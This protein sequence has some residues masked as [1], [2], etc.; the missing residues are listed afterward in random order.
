MASKYEPLNR[1]LLGHPRGEFV[2]TFRQVEEVLG[3]ALP[4]SAERPQWWS[5]VTGKDH[6]HSQAWQS[7]GY[8]AFLVTG[9]K[10]VRFASR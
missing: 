8:G 7:A 1:Y 3:F 2:L 10:E 4:K 5:N 6:P 9:R